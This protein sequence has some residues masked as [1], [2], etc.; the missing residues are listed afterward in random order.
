M[1]NYVAGLRPKDFSDAGNA[2]VFVREYGNDL[3]FTDSMGWLHWGGKRW[4][5]DEHKALELA[6]DFTDQM[7]AEAKR[8]NFDAVH[9]LAD[10]TAAKDAGTPDTAA[11]DKA[12]KAAESAKLYLNHALKTRQASRVRAILELA[13]PY[14]VRLGSAF[15]AEPRALNTP[16][17]IVDLVNGE[18]RPNQ[19]EALCSKV[20]AAGRN[21]NGADIWRDFLATITCGSS[22]LEGFLQTVIGMS[23]YGAVYQEGVTFAVGDGKNGK[24]TFFNAVAAVLG[25][26]AGYIDIDV[27]TTKN[28]NDKAALATLRGKRLVIAGELEEGRRLSA[29]TIKKIS[30]TDPFQVEEKYKQPE[31]VKPS[32]TLCLFTSHLPRVG[33]TD[34]GTWRRIIV[35]PFSAT[36]RPDKTIQNYGEYLVEHCS[37]AI[38]AWA[39]QGA[40]NFAKNGFSL[41]LPDCVEEATEEYRSRENWLE[42]FIDDCCERAEGARAGARELYL[43]YKEWAQNAGERYI[44]SEK[45]FSYEL[46]RLG[47]RKITPKN[48]K[49]WLGIALSRQNPAHGYDYDVVL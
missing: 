40:Q 34:S 4:E 47:F 6:E 19:R 30:S 41:T 48:R 23:L 42:N 49:T 14:L 17:G 16:I 25:D 27:I 13:R 12:K 15:D 38:L 36:I 3:I 33:S 37:G 35:V 43:A 8:L 26:Y 7:L 11:L 45:E 21:T 22:E 5:R 24:S 1:N 39:V 31:I 28:G 44:R 10:Q 32:H 20:T 46:D 29:A 2:E 9:E 18:L